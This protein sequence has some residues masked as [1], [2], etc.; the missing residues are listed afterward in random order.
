MNRK[1]IIGIAIAVLVIAGIA[2]GAWFLFRE[3]GR[4]ITADSLR[5]KEEYE[6]RN[7]ELDE[8]GNHI[9]LPLSIDKR[10]NVVY[11]SYEELLFFIE[12][13]TGLL[14]FGNSGS[15]WCRMLAPSLLNFAMEDN[16]TIYYYDIEGDR[17]ENNDRYKKIISLLE[18]HLPTDTFSQSEGD[19]D[20]DPDLKILA[21]PHLFFFKIG[22][23]KAE[24]MLY[25]HHYLSDN[26]ADRVMQLLRDK[27]DTIASDDCG[28]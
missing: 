7:N 28:C 8:E 21:V 5:F 13:R 24:A 2:I 1:V 25:Q 15:E 14:F 20:F 27:F 10:N 22:E 17:E 12:Y 4:A 19:P 23:V 6:S 18:E 26:R 3:P 11:L 16:V 9:Y